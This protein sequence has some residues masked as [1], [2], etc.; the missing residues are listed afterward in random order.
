[1][2]ILTEFAIILRN[3]ILV[4][5]AVIGGFM[6]APAIGMPAW[7]WGFALIPAGLLF[8]KLSGDPIPRFGRWFP[9]AIALTLI[10][11]CVSAATA[12]LRHTFPIV[13]EGWHTVFFG[14]A[15]ALMPSIQT[16]VRWGER[17][18]LI[19]PVEHPPSESAPPNPP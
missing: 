14:L 12:W 9:I 1:M 7:S 13:S 8:V 2:K 5:L 6:I 11:S 18:G 3:T 15:L 4:T 16:V 17:F 19:S 10:V